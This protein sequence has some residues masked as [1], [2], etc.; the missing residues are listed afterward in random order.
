[1]ADVHVLAG[2]AGI[3][4]LVCHIPIPA[5]NN[6]ANPPISYATAA[7]RAKEAG[8]TTLPDG[9]GNGGTISAAEKTSITNGTVVEKAV[10]FDLGND[11]EGLTGP[12]RLARLDAKYAQ[13]V[14]DEQ[15]RLTKTLRYTG[16]VR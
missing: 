1:M 8:T 7:L 9:D 5:G 12:Q 2:S 6:Q 3:V 15:A 16:F 13:V 14:A 10:D 11:W 4:R